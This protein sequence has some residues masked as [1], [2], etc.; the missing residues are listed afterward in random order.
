LITVAVIDDHPLTRAGVER[1]LKAARDV[2]VVCSAPS[3]QEFE[4]SATTP[5]IIVLDLY[6]SGDEPD[7][8]VVSALSAR[9]QVLVFSASGRGRDVLAAIE[10]GASGYITKQAAD[11]SFLMAVRAV[12]SGGF[13]LSSQ[14]AD[15]MHA[16]ARSRA[17]RREDPG[18]SAREMEALRLIA[19]GFTHAQGAARM[20]VSP[21]TFDTYVKRVREK[22]GPA[23]K[24]GLTR[25]AIELGLGVSTDAN[26]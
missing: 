21:S 4:A 15:L 16:E 17:D 22:L 12:A 9:T 18:L 14:L 8:E 5:D 13:Y 23:N 19:E 25:K 24:A 7:L 2:Q 10:A 1:S 20:G 11:E 6:L 3:L 26:E